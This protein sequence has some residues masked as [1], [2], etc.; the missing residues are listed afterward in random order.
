MSSFSLRVSLVLFCVVRVS[1]HWDCFP[2]SLRLISLYLEESCLVM[3]LWWVKVQWKECVLFC[4]LLVSPQPIF[5]RPVIYAF[6]F[7]FHLT[8]SCLQGVILLSHAGYVFELSCKGFSFNIHLLT[9]GFPN[10]KFKCKCYTC[11]MVS[12]CLMLWITSQ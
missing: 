6:Y 12:F 7:N 9:S 4:I 3:Q 1:Q 2:V 8:I 11:K 5:Y 10:F